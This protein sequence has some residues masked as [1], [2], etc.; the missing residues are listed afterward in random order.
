MF[1][2]IAQHGGDVL[3]GSADDAGKGIAVDGNGSAYVVGYTRS[4][5]FPTVNPLRA[6]LSGPSD[7]FIR[8]SGH[9]AASPQ[10]FRSP[11]S[12][13]T[14]PCSTRTGASMRSRPERQGWAR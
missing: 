6:T 1:A 3:G 13:A 5:N 10:S 11:G 12:S 7:A 2:D 4:A 8:A 9:C 14:G